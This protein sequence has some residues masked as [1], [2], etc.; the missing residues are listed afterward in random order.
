MTQLIDY[1][2]EQ[3]G[4]GSDYIDAWGKPTTIEPHNQHKLLNKYYA[5]QI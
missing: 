4:I 2:I 5:Y 1:L 3:R